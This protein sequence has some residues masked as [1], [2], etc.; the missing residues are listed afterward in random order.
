MFEYFKKLYLLYKYHYTEHYNNN[1]YYKEYEFYNNLSFDDFE[2]IKPCNYSLTGKEFKTKYPNYKCGVLT[3]S[4][5]ITDFF[6]DYERTKYI[7]ECISNNKKPGLMALV[8]Y[9][10]INLQYVKNKINHGEINFKDLEKYLFYHHKY[11]KEIK[12]SKENEF[13]KFRNNP[14]N[15]KN[16]Y[17][18]IDTNNIRPYLYNPDF[19]IIDI[20]LDDEEIIQVFEINNVQKFFI[21]EKN[22]KILDMYEFEDKMIFQMVKKNPFIIEKFLRFYDYMYDEEIQIKF[23]KQNCLCAKYMK[24][25]TSKAKEVLQQEIEKQL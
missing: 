1:Y 11:D 18:I 25:I 5:K 3:F 17:E 15:F 19:A 22:I 6:N 12:L 24:K 23:I 16:L 4:S 2:K 10:G 14:T 9:S 7:D 20:E 8:V 13:L 21:K